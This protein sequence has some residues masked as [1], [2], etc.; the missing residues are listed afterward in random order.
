M[1]FKENIQTVKNFVFLLFLKN[2]KERSVILNLESHE[3]K[4]KRGGNVLEGGVNLLVFTSGEWWAMKT[5]FDTSNVSS[6][7][8][9]SFQT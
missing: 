9:K 3:E 5:D 2:N 4:K 6:L 8:L 7:V 1:F